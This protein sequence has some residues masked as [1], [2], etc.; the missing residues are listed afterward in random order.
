MLALL[1]RCL[2]EL[3]ILSLQGY[4]QAFRRLRS[5]LQKYRA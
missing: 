4:K 3:V 1:D 2:E 5:A